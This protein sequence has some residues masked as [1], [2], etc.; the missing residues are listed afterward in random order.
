M[1]YRYIYKTTNI[2]NGKIYIGQ[3][4]TININDK[5]YLGSGKVLHLAIK[6]YGK[7]SFKKE[8]LCFCVSK[9][10]L[11]RIEKEIV[12]REFILRKDTYNISIGGWGGCQGPEGR[13]SEET[14]KKI[15]NTHCNKEYNRMWVNNSKD[16]SWIEKEDLHKWLQSGWKIGRKAGVGIGKKNPMYQKNFSKEHRQQI[17]KSNSGKVFTKE[18][19]KK[20]S[21]IRIGNTATKNR[22]WITKNNKHKMIYPNELKTYLNDD[23]ILGRKDINEL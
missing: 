12:N 22:R 9:Q 14:I 1:K 10:E 15:K 4:T 21:E 7:N 23:W 6:K 5:K 20:L 13:H 19:R 2:V 18:H 8:I 17:S 3:R 11:N 16:E